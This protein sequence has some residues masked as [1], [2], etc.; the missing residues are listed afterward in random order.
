MNKNEQNTSLKTVV[1][2]IRIFYAASLIKMLFKFLDEGKRKE[3]NVC[4]STQFVSLEKEI[5]YSY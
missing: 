1:C 4:I 3:R 5:K 2:I